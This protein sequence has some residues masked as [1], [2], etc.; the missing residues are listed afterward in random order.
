MHPASALLLSLL[1]SIALGV[2][3]RGIAAEGHDSRIDLIWD[4]HSDTDEDLY[5]VY[6]A[7]SAAGPWTR[8]NR[9]P[10][11]I[12]VYSDFVGENG[13]TFHYRV[14]RIDQ[15]RLPFN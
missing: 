5:N 3:P 2:P 6:R 12:H 13:K 15:P 8:L 9:Q 4:R 14:T 10:H 11:T 7:E 1:A